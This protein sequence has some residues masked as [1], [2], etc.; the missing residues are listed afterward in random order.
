[1]YFTR[2]YKIGCRN[3]QNINV[4]GLETFK[5]FIEVVELLIIGIS[6]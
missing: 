6:L 2:L 3:K 5:L 4:K 1:M